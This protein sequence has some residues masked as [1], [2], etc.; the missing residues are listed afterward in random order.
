MVLG[1][2]LVLERRKA[3][4]LVK[5]ESDGVEFVVCVVLEFNK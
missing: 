2:I 1:C 5:Q 4:G 3:E